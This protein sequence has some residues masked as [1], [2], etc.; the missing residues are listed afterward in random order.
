M[1]IVFEDSYYQITG[2]D[3]LDTES[4]KVTM[5]GAEGVTIIIPVYGGFESLKKTVLVYNVSHLCI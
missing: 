5:I 1:I 4:L 3:L 2:A